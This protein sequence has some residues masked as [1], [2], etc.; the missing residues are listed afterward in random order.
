MPNV[1]NIKIIAMAR[2]TRIK[3][4]A[5][6]LPLVNYSRKP[7]F[8]SSFFVFLA[9]C[10]CHKEDSDVFISSVDNADTIWVE[11]ST[12]EAKQDF[13]KLLDTLATVPVENLISNIKKNQTISIDSDL[14]LDLPPNGFL[15]RSGKVADGPASVSVL[16]LTSRG[17]M[18]KNKISG[19]SNGQVLKTEFVLRLVFTQNGTELSL[20]NNKKIEIFIGRDKP[21]TGNQLFTNTPVADRSNWTD[22]PNG[23]ISTISHN[24]KKGYSL[25]LSQL[26]WMLA[27]Q[28]INAA[29]VTTI[30]ATLPNIFTNA[31]SKMYVL[32]NDR[33]GLMEMGQNKNSKSFFANN[34][35]LGA[36]VKVIS[37]SSVVNNFYLGTEDLEV[38]N[39]DHVKLK[40]KLVS[41]PE[42]NA[43]MNGLR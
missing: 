30:T 41:Y 43:Y 1:S 5:L 19:I 23:Q 37:V 17:E 12:T 15:D 28:G 21:V 34:I 18:L 16:Y 8:I 22:F 38:K 13:Q 24:S 36:S 31:N 9:L 29:Q 20:S 39:K 26:P 42:L 4:A 14:I 40:P 7:V 3:C 33:N 10:S 11:N 2:N 27:G 6:I 25:L 32:L 35:P